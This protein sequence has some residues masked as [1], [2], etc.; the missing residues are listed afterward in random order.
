MKKISIAEINSE[1]ASNPKEYIEECNKKYEGKLKKI[2][3]DIVNICEEKP[4]ILLAG[5]S[6]SGKTTSALKLETMLEKKGIQTHTI[7][8]DDYFLPHTAF[9]ENVLN[10]D[11]KVDYESPY[12]IDIGLLNEHMQKMANC[13]E[14]VSPKF[15]FAT[16][17]VSEGKTYR[18][19]KG[20]I[21]IIEGIHALNPLVTGSADDFCSCMYV[22]VRTRLELDDGTLVHPCFLRLMRRILRDKNF[23]GRSAAETLDLYN[24][25]QRGESKYILPFK[26]RAAYSVDTF[27]PYEPALYKPMLTEELEKIENTYPFFE[28]YSQTLEVLHKVK[29]CE[30]RFVPKDSLP[31]EFIGGSVYEY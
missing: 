19:Q 5:P 6:G 28:K 18:R 9:T 29:P 12:R 3:L 23:R 13:E 11:G 8:M 16:Q 31:R 26:P 1:I 14:I 22:S 30:E 17:T 27:L 10:E 2:A 24:N 20:E 15:H 21:V 25:V 7:S 4:I